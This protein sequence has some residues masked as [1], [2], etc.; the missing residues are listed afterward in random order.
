M[1][2]WGIS[3]LVL[4]ELLLLY[5]TLLGCESG[6]LLI[7]LIRLLVCLVHF[8]NKKTTLDNLGSGVSRVI[9]HRGNLVSLL[10]P[11]LRSDQRESCVLFFLNLGGTATDCF[12]HGLHLESKVDELRAEGSHS[13]GRLLGAL[14]LGGFLGAL[15]ACLALG[16][17]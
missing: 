7:L 15:A 17:L 1:K 14:P 16:A 2:Q 12:L 8:W 5:I 9:I 11:C 4:R 3:H 6:T 13:L 10:Q